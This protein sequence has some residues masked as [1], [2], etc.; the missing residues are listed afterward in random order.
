M[1]GPL[2]DMDQGR[3]KQAY[4][5]LTQDLEAAAKSA[6]PDAE[7]AWRS[8]TSYYRRGAERIEKALDKS[9]KADSPERAFEA[10]VNMAG[11][12]RASA[13]AKRMRRIK[14]SMPREEWNE[15]AATIVDRIGRSK[16]GAQSA[17]G[18]EFSPGVF[19]TEWN[20]MSDEAKS[21]LFPQE[22]RAQLTK[23]AEVSELAKSANAE[24]NFSNSGQIVV[25]AA[26]GAGLASAPL[27]TAS[28]LLGANISSRALTSTRMLRAMNRAARG[29]AKQLRTIANGGGPLAQDAQTILRMTAA[30]SAAGGNAANAMTEPRLRANP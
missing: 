19:L 21:V 12:N 22:T 2:A 9:I 11:K 14:A 26:S 28:I 8:A 17:A 18:D 24:R 25:G 7:K 13:D 6:G 30:E 10:F 5:T 29:D 3:I 23:L 20:K 4:G 27:T 16:P 15:M 1:N